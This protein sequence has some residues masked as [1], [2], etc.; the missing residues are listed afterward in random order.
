MN[1]LI[2]KIKINV[3]KTFKGKKV[4]TEIISNNTTSMSLY[5][6]INIK[7]PLGEK[8]YCFLNNSKIGIP[9]FIN[10]KQIHSLKTQINYLIKS[11]VQ[12]W[13]IELN[14]NGLGFKSFKIND[15]LALDI[16]YSS[17]VIYKPNV[18]IHIKTF[19][20]KIVLFSIDQDYVKIAADIIRNYSAP[21]PYRKK[22]IL[23]KNQILK[24][25]KKK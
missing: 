6:F 2:K 23:F 5:N 8:K 16:G 22:G 17:L 24:L 1:N 19:K 4:S 25:K 13:F 18:N 20:N 3:E 12:G 14:L 10:K 21:D 7:G 11:V 15:T 9:L